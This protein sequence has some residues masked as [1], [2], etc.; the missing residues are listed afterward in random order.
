[1]AAEVHVARYWA[2]LWGSEQ[3][4]Q[5]NNASYRVSNDVRVVRPA[6]LLAHLEDVRKL[7]LRHVGALRRDQ[8]KTIMILDLPLPIQ[9]EVG[10]HRCVT[11]HSSKRSGHIVETC[12]YL[13]TENDI[14]RAF[15]GV[16]VYHSKRHGTMYMM[17]EFLVHVLQRFNETFCTRAVRRGLAE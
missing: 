2:T 7:G 12:G 10:A 16:L 9:V 3:S 6:T 5:I 8:A 11:C 13:V 15:P 1:M 14:K 17:R 4:A